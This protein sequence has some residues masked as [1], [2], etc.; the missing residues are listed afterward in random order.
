MTRE[1]D[2]VL[3]K[4][5]SR[6]PTNKVLFFLEEAPTNKVENRLVRDYCNTFKLF[7]CRIGFT[8]RVFIID[9]NSVELIF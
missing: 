2:Y 6:A 4:D 3:K 9:F 5:A 1:K 7:K 8:L